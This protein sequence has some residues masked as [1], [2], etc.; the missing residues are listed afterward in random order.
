MGVREAQRHDHACKAD[1]ICVRSAE[2]RTPGNGQLVVKDLSLT[3]QEGNQVLVVG[4]SG[5]GKTSV[6]RMISGLWQPETGSIERPPLGEL[7]F[8]PQRPYMLL[9]S[10]RKQLC[11][12]LEEGAF[13][14]E[15][16]RTVLQQVNL[17]KF[18]DRYPDF[19]LV[20]DWSHVLSLGE[21]QRLAF[22]R[23]LLNSPK[24]VVLDEATSALDVATERDLYE[25]LRQKGIAYISVGHRPT[26]AAFHEQVLELMGQDGGG[27]WRMMPADTYSFAGA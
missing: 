10:F 3:I 14:D 18:I 16:L 25:L 26:L 8:I 21:Q 12:P 17:A 20:Q 1:A 9:G 7:L 6:L 11:Y 2:L 22:G 15:Q 24:F 4:P 5:C 23:L 13:T 19:G 27:A